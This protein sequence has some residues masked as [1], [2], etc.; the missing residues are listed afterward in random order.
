M[1]NVVT[2]MKNAGFSGAQWRGK[3][4]CDGVCSNCAHCGMTLTDALSI[5][6]GLGP[7]CRKRGGFTADPEG[8]SDEIV[9][10]ARLGDFPELVEY[11]VQHWGPKGARGLMNGLVRICSLNR[12]SPV[13]DACTDAIEIL[14]WK[15]LASVLR[16]SLCVASIKEATTA[17]GKLVVWIKKSEWSW[18]WTSDLRR[19]VPTSYQSRAERGVIFDPSDKRI[20]WDLLKKHYAGFCIMNQE[21]KVSRIPQP[22][23]T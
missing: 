10:M 6:V 8:D 15:S 23:V 14:G 20:V 2:Q 22:E 9:A 17:T 5:E 12:K 18:S 4:L 11:L 1:E 16:E 3:V 21:K 13:H 7:V 19:S